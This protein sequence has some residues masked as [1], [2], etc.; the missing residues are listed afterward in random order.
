MLKYFVTGFLLGIGMTI[1]YL[2]WGSWEWFQPKP[3]WAQ[4]LFYPGLLTGYLLY[5]G[6]LKHMYD[7]GVAVRICQCVGILTMG[8]VV[9]AVACVVRLLSRVRRDTEVDE[10]PQSN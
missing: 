7:F 2:L 10:T 6:W 8:L 3:Q 1:S 5:D 4:I 9:G